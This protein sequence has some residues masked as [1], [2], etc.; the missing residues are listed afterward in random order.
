MHKSSLYFLPNDDLFTISAVY[1]FSFL[2]ARCLFAPSKPLSGFEHY[3]IIIIKRR[4]WRS[5]VC[6]VRICGLIRKLLI[7]LR[8]LPC[9]HPNEQG[10]KLKT[11]L[12]ISFGVTIF[13]SM[14][15]HSKVELWTFLRAA[16]LPFIYVAFFLDAKHF[17]CLFPSRLRQRSIFWWMALSSLH[18]AVFIMSKLHCTVNVMQI[19]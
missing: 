5:K 10:E 6:W 12:A 1:F 17:F 13:L 14:K 4:G 3:D 8:F 19:I 9:S 7:T 2:C 16:N 15:C 18:S 11:Q